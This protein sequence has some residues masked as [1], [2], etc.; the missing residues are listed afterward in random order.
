MESNIIV[1]QLGMKEVLMV[2]ILKK[3]WFVVLI[4]VLP[5]F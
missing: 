2:E 3:N 4:A 5:E 1:R